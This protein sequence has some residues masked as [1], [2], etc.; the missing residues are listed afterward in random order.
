MPNLMQ[1][2]SSRGD[3]RVPCCT[4]HLHLSHDPETAYLACATYPTSMA[5]AV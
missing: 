1:A 3:A 4:T 2:V 5:E